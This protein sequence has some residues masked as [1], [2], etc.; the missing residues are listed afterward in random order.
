VEHNSGERPE[1]STSARRSSSCSRIL[2]EVVVLPLRLRSRAVQ[3]LAAAHFGLCPGPSMASGASAEHL[4]GFLG[5]PGVAF[6]RR[7]TVVRAAE[8]R[9]LASP[10]V[11][12]R[13]PASRRRERSTR[14]LVQEFSRRGQDAIDS[15]VPELVEEVDPGIVPGVSLRI[16]RY[17]HRV[18]RAPNE[19]VTVFDDALLKL[20]RDM[21]KVM[22][23]SRGVG[24]AAPQVGINKRVMVFNPK[25]DPRAWLS[26]VA[27]VNPRI[28]ER[29]EATE[30]GMEGCLSFPGVSGDI[31]RSLM[32][33]VEA[34][35]P[36]GKRFQVKYQGWTA[37]IFQHEYDHLD[38]VLFIDRMKPAVREQNREAL[39]NLMRQVPE[40]ERAL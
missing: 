30:E 36:N 11:R 6:L 9:Q 7:G 18:L 27:L 31:E 39:E 4:C 34:M 32:I 5:L 17:P 24:L 21:F 23:A 13:A 2:V 19:P 10:G 37:R 22:Y 33:K 38:G 28:I 8:R 15:R 26:E 40:S 25:G 3:Q 12:R 35:K 16:V 1:T 20:V 14:T 29:S